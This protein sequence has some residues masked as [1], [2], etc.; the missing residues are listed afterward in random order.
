MRKKRPRSF[1]RILVSMLAW[2]L[3]L[4]TA[5]A[6]VLWWFGPDLVAPREDFEQG[7]G[8]VVAYISLSNQLRSQSE[9]FWSGQDVDF[10]VNEAEFSGMVASAL[11]SNRQPD[12][13]I[14]KVR[15]Y[16]PEG[17]LQID[18][19]LRLPYPQVPEK[20]RNR[21][22][23]LTVDL[24]P[25][26][27]ERGQVEFLITHAKVGRIPVPVSLIKWAGRRTQL[28]IPWFDAKT[29]SIQLPV[30]EMITSNYG[31]NIVIKEFTSSGGKLSLVMAMRKQ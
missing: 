16:L 25:A 29:A 24:Q 12:S 15:A 2:L 26:V 27:S 6:G 21:P 10:V 22:V 1:F 7:P 13:P 5:A 11:L 17:E 8:G 20:F 28:D 23:G 4:A 9:Q 19:I 18:M 14:R 31:R 3:V 30:S